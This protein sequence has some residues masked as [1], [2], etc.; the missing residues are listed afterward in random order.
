MQSRNNDKIFQ[1]RVQTLDNHDNDAYLGWMMQCR[2]NTMMECPIHDMKWCIWCNCPDAGPVMHTPWCK[3][4]M[5]MFYAYI[6][7]IKWCIHIWVDDAHTWVDAHN[8]YP[9]PILSRL[10]PRESYNLE[11][12]HEV[13]TL[14]RLH[15]RELQ[16]VMSH[17]SR[18][19]CAPS[20]SIMWLQRTWGPRFR[21]DIM[22][23]WLNTTTRKSGITTQ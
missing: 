10:T 8:T 2:C 18:H 6:R 11:R 19:Q 5:L 22:V 12:G 9:V 16:W 14:V 17:I 4:M 15:K 21:H 13:R 20:G 1:L 3:I 7:C 23:M